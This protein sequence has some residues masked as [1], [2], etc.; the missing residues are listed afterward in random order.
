VDYTRTHFHNPVIV[1][2]DF[3]ADI[4]GLEKAK[5]AEQDAYNRHTQD[6][7]D[8]EVQQTRAKARG[9][10]ALNIELLKEEYKQLEGELK[11]LHTA[12]G[13][14]KKMLGVYDPVCYNRTLA[15]DE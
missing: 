6:Q 3:S 9:D 11:K 4:S 5:Q 13:L 14:Y 10:K 1:K 7:V 15:K 12:D 8:A 2:H